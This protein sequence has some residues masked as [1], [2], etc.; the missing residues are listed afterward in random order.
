MHFLVSPPC[1]KHFYDNKRKKFEKRLDFLECFCYNIEVAWRDGRVGLRRTTGNR[2]NPN[3]FH[4]F[5][6]H[7][8]RHE[9]STSIMRCSIH[10]LRRKWDSKDERCRADFRWTSATVSDQGGCLRSKLTGDAKHLLR[11]SA[12]RIESRKK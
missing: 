9:S 1:F 4:G 8:L 2:V 12:P 7:S 6:S 10:F 11:S 3:R 5:E